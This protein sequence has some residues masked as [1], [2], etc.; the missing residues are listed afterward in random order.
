MHRRGFTVIELLVVIAVIGAL[1]GLLAP[2]LKGAR[3]SGRTLSCASRLRQIAI[4]TQMYADANKGALPQSRL[5]TPDG[6]GGATDVRATLFG[7]K[8]GSSDLFGANTTGIAQRPVNAYLSSTPGTS[9]DAGAAIE[10]DVFRSPCD[11]GAADLQYGTPDS[12]NVASM[13]DLLGTSYVLNDHGLN[14]P[15]EKTLIPWGGGRMPRVD[16]PARTWLAS[17]SPIYAFEFDADRGQRWYSPKRTEANIAFVDL[18]ARARVSVP[19]IPCDIENDTPDYTFMP[20][21][22][23]MRVPPPPPPM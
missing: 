12:M 9:D 3:E 2:S 16:H 20:R 15:G 18:H 23:W 14:G 22:D 5:A 6:F 13:Y 7:G 8:R 1:V 21:P 4:A 11:R 10:H 17:S 19:N